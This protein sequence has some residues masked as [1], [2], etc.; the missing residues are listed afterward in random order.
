MAAP[1]EAAPPPDLAVRAD[2][3]TPREVEVL[4]LLVDG[5]SDREI[6][7]ALFI[8]PKTAGHHV[9]RILAKLG[10]ASRTAAASYA[11]RQELV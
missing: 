10:V 2:G 9:T 6:A 3:L 7:S 11:L 4:R 8:S 5:C 1:A